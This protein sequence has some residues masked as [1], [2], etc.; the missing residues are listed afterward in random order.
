MVCRFMAS[1]GPH[2]LSVWLWDLQPGGPVDAVEQQAAES[3]HLEVVGMPQ[4][5]VKDA[6]AADVGVDPGDRLVRE[7]VV[8]A[9][10]HERHCAGA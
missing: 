1:F 10:H 8:A 3:R 4:R 5:S 6:T 9:A 7:A 2:M